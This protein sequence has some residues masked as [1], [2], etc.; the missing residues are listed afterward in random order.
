MK[1]TPIAQEIIPRTDRWG[2]IKL[3]SAAKETIATV[4]MQFMTKISSPTASEIEGNI[5]NM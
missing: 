4:K 1:R 2:C 5:K 3:K